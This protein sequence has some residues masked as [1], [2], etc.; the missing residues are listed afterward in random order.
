MLDLTR[1]DLVLKGSAAFAAYAVLHASRANAFPSR[2]GETVIPWADQP[3]PLDDPT[4]TR[5]AGVRPRLSSVLAMSAWTV[6]KMPRSPW[7]WR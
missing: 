4:V 1:R 3:P 2:P 7:S 6:S 5:P